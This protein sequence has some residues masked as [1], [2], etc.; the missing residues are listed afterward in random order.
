MLNIGLLI[1][2]KREKETELDGKKK[3]GKKV[4]EKINIFILYHEGK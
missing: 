4:T 2:Q 1:G 3:N